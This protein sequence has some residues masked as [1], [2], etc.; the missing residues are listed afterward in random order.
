MINTLPD[1]LIEKF[2]LR[3]ASA[4]KFPVEIQQFMFSFY[5]YHNW[6]FKKTLE[7]IF[8]VMRSGI[9]CVEKC[10]YPQC[11][12]KRKIQIAG[13]KTKVLECC[14]VGHASKY[15][16]LKKYGVENPS[17]LPTTIEKRKKTNLEK[18]G[19]ESFFETDVFKKQAKQTNLEKYGC[20]FPSQN[21]TVKEKKEKTNLVKY[22]FKHALQ[23]N[24]IQQKLKNTNLLR[25]GF[26][27]SLLNSDV[28]EKS[29]NTNLEKYG[30]EHSLSNKQVWEKSVNSIVEKYGVTNIMR[31]VPSKIKQQNTMFEIYGVHSPM[32]HE[33]LKWKCVE[34]TK[35]S[36]MEKYGVDNVMHIPHIVDK[37]QRHSR[38]NKTFT[39]KT[40]ETVY[41]QGYEPQ[42]LTEL[43]QNGYGF[44]DV[45][46]NKGD[47][48]KIFYVYE[49]KKH[50]Y[51]AD[52][53]IP[54]EHLIIEVKSEY[55]MQ[56]NLQVNLLKKQA[57]VD[58]GFN[59]KFDVR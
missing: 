13:K 16:M 30:C 11:E 32:L 41:V 50:R 53:F 1:F 42:V 33:Q 43:E 17:H 37:A 55:Y 28:K 12:S 49:S 51:Y 46:T 14:G 56:K 52:I 29:K 34:S 21:Q 45:K 15:T 25:Y 47:M 24:D 8:V 3:H 6:E 7:N 9:T 5:D 26:E 20:E 38:S 40:G 57:C 39:W 10:A 59:F 23:N 31:N 48:P 22:G 58:A 44:N 2:Q 35:K 54:S 36:N 4:K 19:H 18:Y 27:Y